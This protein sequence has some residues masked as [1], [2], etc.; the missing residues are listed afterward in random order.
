MLHY[1]TSAGFLLLS[2]AEYVGEKVADLL[3]ITASRYQYVI[4]VKDR[5]ERRARMEEEEEE[6][7]RREAEQRMLGQQLL[8]SQQLEEGAK[9]GTE[10]SQRHGSEPPLDSKSDAPSA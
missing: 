5:E 2:G 1:L 7:A 4:D 6:A 10:A 9:A 8:H 3:G